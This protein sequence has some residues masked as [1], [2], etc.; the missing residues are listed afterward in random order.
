MTNE[1]NLFEGLLGAKNPETATDPIVGAAHDQAADSTDN[2]YVRADNQAQDTNL[3]AVQVSGNLARDNNRLF[4]MFRQMS[5]QPKSD[6]LIHGNLP[7]NSQSFESNEPNLLPKNSFFPPPPVI[8]PN[9]FKTTKLYEMTLKNED[10]PLGAKKKDDKK[11]PLPVAP[12]KPE[13]PVCKCNREQ[14]QSLLDQMT[15][16]HGQYNQDMR[17][18]F[19]RIASELNCGAVPDSFSSN[20]Q[21][22]VD[23]SNSKIPQNNMNN[24][25]YFDNDP[26]PIN[27]VCDDY[28]LSADPELAQMCGNSA[29]RQRSPQRA[30]SQGIDHRYLSYQDYVRGLDNVNVNPNTLMMANHFEF[31]DEDPIVGSARDSNEET[32]QLLKAYMKDYTIPEEVTEPPKLDAKSQIKEQIQTLLDALKTRKSKTS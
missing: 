6:N 8:G 1:P 23:I 5:S 11:I 22:R 25:N 2:R 19:T 24:P 7:P 26:N 28:A 17:G 14:I 16:I 21:P 3:Q 27:I 30:A 10:V 29:Y 31:K 13:I 18:L 20:S 12:P 15:S 32:G 9:P 4:D